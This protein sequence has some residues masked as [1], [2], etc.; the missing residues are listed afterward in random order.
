[1]ISKVLSQQAVHTI[2]PWLTCL[3]L[4]LFMTVF[5][6]AV[7]WVNRKENHKLYQRLSDLPLETDHEVR[8]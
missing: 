7:F 1:M 8:L 6:G 3:G 5:V 4:L 2:L